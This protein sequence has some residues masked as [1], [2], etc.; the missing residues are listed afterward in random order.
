MRLAGC[1]PQ[2]APGRR[3]TASRRGIRAQSC[4][5]GEAFIVA[6]IDTF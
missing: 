1:R 4:G 6:V 5:H 3:L 2:P